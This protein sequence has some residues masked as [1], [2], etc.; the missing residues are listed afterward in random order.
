M[1]DKINEICNKLNREQLSVYGAT[2]ELFDLFVVSQRSELFLVFAEF[3]DQWE[4]DNNNMD[5]NEV[6]VNK[7][8]K[9]NNCGIT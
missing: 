4:H 2:N 3:K 7:F 6:I 5:S 1:K 9:T 8:L